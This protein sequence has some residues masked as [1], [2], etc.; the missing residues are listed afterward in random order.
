MQSN[1][2]MNTQLWLLYLEE[3]CGSD[4]FPGEQLVIYQ[5]L[6][7]LENIIDYLFIDYICIRQGELV[8]SVLL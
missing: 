5:L 2:C 7:N 4:S 1:P 8:I 3:D 6:V